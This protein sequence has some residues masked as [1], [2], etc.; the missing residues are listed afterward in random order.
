M[1]DLVYTIFLCGTFFPMHD[2]RPKKDDRP[3]L[4]SSVSG[5]FFP[6]ALVYKRLFSAAC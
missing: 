5:Q 1:A 3:R 2:G 4:R 6:F